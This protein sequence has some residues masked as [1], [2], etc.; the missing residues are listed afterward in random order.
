MKITSGRCV[1]RCSMASSADSA[2]STEISYFSRILARKLRADFESSTM[3]ARFAAMERLDRAP[4]CA[5]QCSSIP[6]AGA[7]LEQDH[8]EGEQSHREDRHEEEG[9]RH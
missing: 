4:G 8:G 3:S 2:V 5:G 7:A 6:H 1:A 9:A